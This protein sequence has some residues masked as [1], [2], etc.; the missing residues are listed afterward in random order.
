VT[1]FTTTNPSLRC[2]S[3]VPALDVFAVTADPTRYY[4]IARKDL[5][6]CAD[7]SFTFPAPA[8]ASATTTTSTTVA[9]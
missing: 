8:G 3:T 6:D 7:A 2:L 5:G 4:V 9:P 1:G